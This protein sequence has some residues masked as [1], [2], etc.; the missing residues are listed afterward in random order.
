[1]IF[2]W[3]ESS[4][5]DYFAALRLDDQ[6]MWRIPGPMAQAITLRAVGALT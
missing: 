5:K 4:M 3:I 2:G 6:I 1:M